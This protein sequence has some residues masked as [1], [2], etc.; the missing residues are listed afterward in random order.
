MKVMYYT[1]CKGGAIPYVASAK[2]T[3]FIN[4]NPVHEPGEI[5]LEFGGT[6]EEALNK[7]KKRLPGYN[8]VEWEKEEKT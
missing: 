1:I 7:L 4:G 3:P 6:R 5:Q 8:W 2:R